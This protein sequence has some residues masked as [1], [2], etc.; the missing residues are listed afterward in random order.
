MPRPGLRYLEDNLIEQIL[1][2][3]CR[4][5]DQLGIEIKNPNIIK[6]LCDHGARYV[7]SKNRL[8][9]P[10]ALIDKALSTV[11]PE[12]RLYDQ[13]GKQTHHFA[14][15]NVYYTPGSSAI[16]I[17]DQKLGRMR[18]PDTGD[19]IA[20]TKLT[21]G[22]PHIQSQSTAMIPA[23]VPADIQ[24]AYRLLLS[25]LYCDKAI[26]TGA[27][28]GKSFELM[29]EM[30]LVV[31]GTA[32]ELAAKPLSVF[33][34][35]SIAPLK[36][37]DDT[38]QNILDCAEAGVPIELISMPMSG[39]T[40]PVTLVGSLIQHTAENLSGLVMS[41]LAKPGMPVLYGGSTAP[42]DIRY[43]MPPMGAVESQMISCAYSE[44]GKFLG[45]PTQ[46]YIC[47]SD[48]KR[49]DAQMGL[50]SAMGATQA[51]L[52]G[53]NSIA[54]PGMHDYE[55]CVSPEK[56]VIDNEIAGM[57][58]R[59][60]HGITARDDFPTIPLLE[61][62]Q[63]D[64]HL[65]I[66][67]HTRRFLKEEHYFPGPVIERASTARWEGEGSRSLSDRAG[68]EV[69]RIIDSWVPVS[70]S[71]EKREELIRMTESEA[72]RCGLDKLPERPE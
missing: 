41:Q 56:L 19:Y 37:S 34:C 14:N 62:L 2:E 47:L 51:A 65:L 30:Q 15:D 44:I 17:L 49:I 68:D 10:K 25:L 13:N 11:P 45:M 70:L 43:E 67:K 32:E 29:K 53:I 72:V 38:S 23:D 12:F 16:S 31:R 9:L 63:R 59:M 24:D 3:A 52:S 20:Y 35:C 6:L 50:E 48:A 42:F 46:A 61:E 7:E 66:A 8:F 36:W 1:D 28:T 54:G 27:F 5:L 69:K 55:S 71:R 57:T 33:S 40:A 4:I 60:K 64:G 18:S 26:F 58:L 39:F 22:L 21:A